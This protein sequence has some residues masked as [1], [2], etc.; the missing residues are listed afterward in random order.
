MFKKITYKCTPSVVHPFI[1]KVEKEFTEKEGKKKTPKAPPS[2]D[3]EFRP[4]SEVRCEEGKFP[5]HYYC[6]VR[7][8][9]SFYKQ[10]QKDKI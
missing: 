4:G 7:E 2:F 3:V 10:L 5:G 8:W 9:C 1:K 6:P